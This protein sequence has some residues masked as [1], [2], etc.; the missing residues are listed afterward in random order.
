MMAKTSLHARLARLRYV[1]GWR[2][3]HWWYDTRAGRIAKL[4]AAACMLIALT[5][6][7]AQ[8]AVQAV[9]HPE[10]PRQAIIWMVVWLIV[11]LVVSL[12]LALTASKP[13]AQKPDTQVTT[14]TT[15]DGQSAVRHY[16][17][18]WIDSPAM[19]AWKITGRD[20]IKTKSGKK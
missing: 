6:M 15:K 20:P 2:L 19:L 14:P 11:T 10:A 16:G 17:T 5:A 13:A 1:Y 3:R 12:Y 8:H 18:V 7:I 4:S 9:L